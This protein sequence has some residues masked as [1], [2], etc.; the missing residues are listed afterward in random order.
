M[1]SSNRLTFILCSFSRQGRWRAV[2]GLIG[3]SLLVSAHGQ[4]P[5]GLFKTERVTQAES[6]ASPVWAA[7]KASGNP[8]SI[9]T[10]PVS[11]V[12]VLGV[13]N[14]VAFSVG[15]G[16]NP[17]PTFQWL[18]NGLP[19]LQATQSSLTLPTDQVTNT[20]V[21]AVVVANSGG[22]IT[23]APATLSFC[24][25]DSAGGGTN[26]LTIYG[27]VGYPYRI[28]FRDGFF[29]SY[30]NLTGFLLATSPSVLLDYP[31]AGFRSYKVYQALLPHFLSPPRLFGDTVELRWESETNRVIEIYACT[32]LSASPASWFRIATVTN[33]TGMATNLETV[34]AGL[35]G[36]FYKAVQVR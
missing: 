36:R 11:Q 32:N 1:H 34:A 35:P 6:L 10:Q 25:A 16:G 20:G 5:A 24:R 29:G 19:L 12:V 14:P 8:P 3:A 27:L 21:Y 4:S 23:S 7:P 9:T 26:R 33:L 15:A 28:D 31:G 17:S 2:G 30:S 13:G 22:S 18:Y